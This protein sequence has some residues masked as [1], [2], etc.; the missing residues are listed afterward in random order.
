[1]TVR[2]DRWLWA[3]RFF[4]T[5]SLAAQAVAGGKVHVNGE[6]PK[7]AKAVR[8]GDRLRVRVGPYEHDV[9]VRALSGRRGSARAAAALY[10]ETPE[11][12]SGRAKLAEQLR[13]APSIR[14]E[15]K[16]RP[17]KKHRRALRRL[18]GD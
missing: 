11:S 2:I 9:T 5:R 3:A 1:M 13:L 15:G 10:E 12:R 8:P 4:K 16:G 18:Q 6:R 14:Y 7:P 17:T